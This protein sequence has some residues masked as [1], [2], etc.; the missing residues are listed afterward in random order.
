MRSRHIGITG[1]VLLGVLCT[2]AG[3]QTAPKSKGAEA[4][5][6][7]YHAAL[8]EIEHL[9]QALAQISDDTPATDF[10]LAGNAYVALHKYPEAIAAYTRA[11]AR[12]PHEALIVRHRGMAY[13]AL[14]DYPHAL[15]D[16]TRALELDPQDAVAYNHRGVALYASNNPAQA[17]ADFDK[18]IALQPKLA[19][20]YHNRGMVWR[21]LGNVAQSGKDFTVAAQF[22]ITLASQHLQTLQEEIRQAQERLRQAGMNPGPPDGVAGPQT[23][24]ALATRVIDFGLD[25]AAVWAGLERL[26][27]V[28]I[29]AN[30]K[31][32]R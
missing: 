10:F 28:R 19:Q 32:L 4:L 22:G 7:K 17:L 20:A 9:K 11:I 8:Q 12:A 25:E 2:L 3:A 16:L 14:G 15:A 27:V 13:T 31:P 30:P 1:G 18:A 26:N 24:A 29:L 5:R 6:T 23:L 21:A